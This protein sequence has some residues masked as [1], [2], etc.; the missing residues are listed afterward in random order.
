MN[1]E[2]SARI[3]AWAGA[4]LSQLEDDDPVALWLLQHM[5]LS[6]RLTTEALSAV[7]GSL[8]IGGA[9]PEQG[10]IKGGGREL[11]LRGAPWK[12]FRQLYLAEGEAV[13]RVALCKAVECSNS[14]LYAAKN[15]LDRELNR[16]FGVAVRI[17]TVHGAGYRLRNVVESGDAASAG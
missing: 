17:I 12:L 13:T 15:G 8:T 5:P 7:V 16:T 9:T 1:R 10:V 14:G 4:Q 6:G 11:L 3:L 2:A